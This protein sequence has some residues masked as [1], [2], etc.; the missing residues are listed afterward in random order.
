ML[1]REMMR[2]PVTTLQAGERLQEACHL[3]SSLGFRHL[4]VLDGERLVGVLTDPAHWMTPWGR[5]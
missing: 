3:F 4:P 2:S 1:V 5:P